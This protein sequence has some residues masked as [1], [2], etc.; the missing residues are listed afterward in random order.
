MF[1][2]WGHILD[3]MLSKTAPMYQRALLGASP[4]AEPLGHC[5]H[6]PCAR[7][8]GTLVVVPEQQVPVTVLSLQMFHVAG[9]P[10]FGSVM[11]AGACPAAGVAMVLL[12]AWMALMSRT[13]VR[14]LCLGGLS[15]GPGE[16]GQGASAAL[17]P[18]CVGQRRCSVLAPTTASHTGSC[19]IGTRTV[20]T[21]GTRR[22]V[23]SSPVC[24]GSG[25]AGTGCAS[26]L[27]GSAT[28]LMTVVIPQMKMSA[29][30]ERP[31]CSSVERDLPR[32]CVK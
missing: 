16:T 20:R 10:M 22:A 7:T 26:W 6:L 15:G 5:Q 27:T 28:G 18:Q 3:P 31:G 12:T 30:S 23:L 21:A 17:F 25:S 13:V 24:L 14:S 32:P 4:L 19:A 8:M 29:V 2:A 1:G 9:I 11:M